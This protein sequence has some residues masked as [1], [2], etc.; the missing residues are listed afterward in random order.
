M[1]LNAGGIFFMAF[2]WGIIITLTVYTFYKVLK[3]DKKKED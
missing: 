1:S 2:A 3:G